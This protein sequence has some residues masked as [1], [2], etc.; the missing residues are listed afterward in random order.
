MSRLFEHLEYLGPIAATSGRGGAGE[1][2]PRL[3]AHLKREL[4][5]SISQ[6]LG[7]RKW[8]FMYKTG[9][10]RTWAF[11]DDA[12]TVSMT[13]G[14][15][16]V[17][18]SGAVLS[19]AYEKGIFEVTSTGEQST[20]Y[21]I[22]EVLSTTTFK[23]DSRWP[24]DTEA[25]IS[26]RIWQQRYPCAYDCGSILI[27]SVRMEGTSHALHRIARQEIE[28]RQGSQGW[29]GGDPNR[30]IDD[31]W[32]GK[33]LWSHD[34]SPSDSTIDVTAESADFTGTDMA[35]DDV[36]LQV[37]NPGDV[38]EGWPIS[39]ISGNKSYR[40]AIKEVATAT[41]GTF[42]E[43]FR[44]P[45]AALAKYEIGRG[46]R[47]IE[48]YPP[49]E[50]ASLFAYLYYRKFFG[51]FN[52]NDESPIPQEWDH[53][54]NDLAAA[55]ILFQA[56]GSEASIAQAR[57]HL[58]NVFGPRGHYERGS[59]CDMESSDHPHADHAGFLADNGIPWE[60]FGY[61][62]EFPVLAGYAHFRGS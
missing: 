46:T 57:Q 45:T 44:G 8:D 26:Y 40:N 18:V 22:D 23:L 43:G 49:P 54:V 24:Y 30:W 12:T 3:F 50:R 39:V 21:N 38:V 48:F 14:K 35:L 10:G 56:K 20:R 16:L 52:D 11:I 47:M 37:D 7:V 60:F 9:G 13:K 62:P 31:Y 59:L 58:V 51:L 29:S 42:H 36:L 5:A 15:R 28:F 61:D 32:K 4:N 55:R 25:G 6:I 53:V 34:I 19:K 17:T 33:P 2:G 41:T 1:T 27:G